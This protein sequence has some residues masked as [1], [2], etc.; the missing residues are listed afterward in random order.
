MRA[1]SGRAKLAP[2]TIARMVR[3]VVICL[4]IPSSSAVP[5]W[6]KRVNRAL[7]LGRQRALCSG[8]GGMAARA[9]GGFRAAQSSPKRSTEALP[10]AT[11]AD[12]STFPGTQSIRYSSGNRLS[13]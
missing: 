3:R 1:A 11:F 8:W 9:S 13:D 4:E 10:H 2:G 12:R 7:T 6:R 5:G